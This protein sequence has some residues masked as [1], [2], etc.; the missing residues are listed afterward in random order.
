MKDKI[1]YKFT[2][3]TGIA[4]VIEV[5]A[6]TSCLSI[7]V[8]KCGVTFLGVIL[9]QAPL[10]P[11]PLI[12]ISRPLGIHTVAFVLRNFSDMVE[13]LMEALHREAAPQ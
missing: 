7:D 12:Q 4:A 13:E 2:D 5:T 3:N 6:M 8:T 1:S 9:I 11:A 10:S